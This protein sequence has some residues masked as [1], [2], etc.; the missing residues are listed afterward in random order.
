MTSVTEWPLSELAFTHPLSPRHF[1]AS[2]ARAVSPFGIPITKQ[3]EVEME[4]VTATFE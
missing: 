3:I 4:T 2:D 1:E